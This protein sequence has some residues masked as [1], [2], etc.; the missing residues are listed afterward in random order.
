MG[1]LDLFKRKVTTVANENI[2]DIFYNHK[3]EEAY[4]K[5]VAHNSQQIL[6]VWAYREKYICLAY[7]DVMCW[8]EQVKFL[9]YA[10][11]I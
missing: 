10:H 3:T 9:E 7:K 6:N 8:S 4:R 2:V 1:F 5:K 11:K